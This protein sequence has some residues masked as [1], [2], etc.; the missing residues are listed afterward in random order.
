MK[1]TM[2][3]IGLVCL[4]TQGVCL[5]AT[6]KEPR[7]DEGGTQSLGSRAIKEGYLSDNFQ[8]QS[9]VTR[10]EMVTVI[11]KLLVEM[12][13][14]HLHLSKSDTQEL[15]NL[16]KIYREYF[17]AYETKLS[18]LDT[19]VEAVMSEQKLLDHEYDG[20]NDA[21]RQEIKL[22]KK[23]RDDQTLHLW[24]GIVGAGLLGLLIK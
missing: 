7:F 21:L 16:G 9:P 10:K 6:S 11:D 23:E 15:K 14:S 12:D 24:M 2:V 22:L 13:T 8:E 17:V 20:L 18:L 5:A 1:K 4:V 3:L 19:K